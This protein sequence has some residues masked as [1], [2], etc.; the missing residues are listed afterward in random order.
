MKK[1][2]ILIALVILL[3]IV[4]GSLSHAFSRIKNEENAVSK[5]VGPIYLVGEVHYGEADVYQKNLLT[6][7]AKEGKIIL[8]IEGESVELS[9]TLIGIE[10]LYMNRIASSLVLLRDLFKYILFKKTIDISGSTIIN[11]KMFSKEEYSEVF[12]DP[13][14]IIPMYLELIFI[15]MKIA[16]LEKADVE[17]REFFQSHLESGKLWNIIMKFGKDPSQSII[18]YLG[19]NTFDDNFYENMSSGPRD[20][21]NWLSRITLY[22]NRKLMPSSIISTSV[23]AKIE[24]AIS[25]WDR[26]FITIES[27]KDSFKLIRAGLKLNEINEEVVDYVSLSLRNE[28]FLTKI[29][30]VYEKTQ[31]LGKPFFV[32]IGAKH[33]LALEEELL[34]KGYRVQI[35]D[36]TAEILLKSEL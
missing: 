32:V 29:C 13:R 6:R 20:W 15:Y 21:Y 19:E 1:S 16:L 14:Y 26:L 25:E 35:N 3:S 9:E 12:E 18:D 28:I 10:E 17:E 22:L 4:F 7:L 36:R 8:A 27:A 33:V 5:E 24:S 30:A 11:G 23:S 34:K 2:T 31:N